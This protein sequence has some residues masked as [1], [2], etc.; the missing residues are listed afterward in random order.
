MRVQ[1]PHNEL[2]PLIKDS[3]DRVYDGLKRLL[4]PEEMIF[5]EL[6][7]GF[8]GILQW[9]LPNDMQWRSFSQ[10]DDYDKQAV[11]NEFIRLKE[12][13][14]KRLGPAQER[15][16]KN[17]YSIPSEASVYY[18]VTPEGKYRIML[19]A[20]GYSFPTQAPMTD[21]TWILPEGAQETTVR[22]IENGAPIANLPIDLHRNGVVL[23]HQLNANGE[24]SYGKLMPGTNLYIEVPSHSKQLTV[25]VMPG[26]T[27]Y[28]FDLTEQKVEPPVITPPVIPEDKGGEEEGPIAVGRDIKVQL[29]GID[30]KPIK[31]R[32]LILG[33]PGR[34]TMTETTDD[35][36][37]IPLSTIDFMEGAPVN[38]NIPDVPEQPSY[39]DSS[40]IIEP[41]ENEY[42]II[43][44]QRT[45]SNFW[46]NALL[47]VVAV[48]LTV[49]T[50]W[51]ATEVEI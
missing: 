23:H 12:L 14:E 22:F 33:Q 39:L 16:I 28:T 36:G 44:K 5:A 42:A 45:K 1:I 19:T 26:Q 30:G 10:A 8:G 9:T 6:A 37:F 46:L 11:I 21:L 51:G 4:A 25:T 27:V 49:L 31:Q 20:W 38:I 3:Y 47:A 41:E 34:D 32:T 2:R 13:G 43:Y 40:F 50:I 48:A 15:L 17:V 18:S 24:K 7:A 35:N 29:I